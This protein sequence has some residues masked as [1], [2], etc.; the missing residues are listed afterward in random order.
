[1]I[2]DPSVEFLNHKTGSTVVL[3]DS[4]IFVENLCR[5]EVGLTTQISLG[6]L[7]ELKT[8]GHGNIVP[9]C[10]QQ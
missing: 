3:M 6:E 1:M 2:G 4:E 9:L 7:T 8:S 10:I 5:V